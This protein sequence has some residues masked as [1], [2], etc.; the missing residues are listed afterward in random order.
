LDQAAE[1]AA[2]PL[3]S[4]QWLWKLMLLTQPA[5]RLQLLQSHW[6]NWLNC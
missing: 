1:V 4:L 6:S 2:L 3:F 5:W